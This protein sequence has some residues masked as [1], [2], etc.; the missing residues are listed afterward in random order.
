MYCPHRRVVLLMLL[1]T[2]AAPSLLA[3]EPAWKEVAIPDD[4]KKA[5]PGDNGWLW[6]RT[7]VAIPAAWRG[8]EMAIV[9]EAADDAR[10]IFVGGQAVGRLGEFPP[11]YRSGLGETKRLIIPE[12]AVQFGSENLLAIRVCNIAARTGFNVAAPVLF[13]GDQAIRLAGKWETVNGDDIAWAKAAPVTVKTAA[14]DKTEDAAVVQRELKK[15]QND[16]G[17]L[18]PV[19]SLARMKTPDDLQV[20]LVLSEP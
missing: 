8:R 9:V 2:L 10:E 1:L 20:D 4:W 7:K 11:A 3:A 12:A 16:D 5:P 15:L 19:E 6:Y 18:S 17:P 14:F 13:G